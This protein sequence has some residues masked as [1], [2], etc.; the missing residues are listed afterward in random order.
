MD[1]YTQQQLIAEIH[2][3]QRRVHDLEDE[4]SLL[5]TQNDFLQEFVVP[6]TEPDS[7]TRDTIPAVPNPNS[8][9]PTKPS[10][11]KAIQLDDIRTALEA[12]DSTR[13][14]VDS[15]NEELKWDFCPI[16]RR[17]DDH[18]HEIDL[19]PEGGDPN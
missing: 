8:N 13:A 14:E 18:E 6:D 7:S 11:P 16:C 4:L 3:L 15:I 5:R 2:R 17:T 12:S 10:S 19:G 9:T 1:K